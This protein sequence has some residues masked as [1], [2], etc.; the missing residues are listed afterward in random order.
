VGIDVSKQSVDVVILEQEQKREQWQEERTPESLEKLARRLKAWSP[1]AVIL[2]ATGGLEARV[3][4]A[5]MAAQVPVIRLNPRR[6]RDFARAHG[7]LAKTDALD[8]YMLALFGSRMRPE[9]RAYP[10]PAQAQIAA[11]LAREQQLTAMRAMER[12]RL[13]QADDLQLRKGIAEVIAF[14][15]EELL[16]IESS[17]AELAKQIPEWDAQEQLL[18]TAPGVGPK[19]A[20]VLLVHLPELGHVNRRQ[21]PRWWEWLRSRPTV[22]SFGDA[23][24]FEVD[25][26]ECGRYCTWRVGPPCAP[27][28]CFRSSIIASCTRANRA[29]SPLSLLFESCSSH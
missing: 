25:E 29:S 19:T 3:I 23:V 6:A 2:E 4:T 8:A 11:W 21:S 24:A 9:V 22:D 28:R 10:D 7:L 5:L 26:A 17:I 18:R 16:R 12:T 20:R 13:E 15:G 27:H 14:L 1:Q